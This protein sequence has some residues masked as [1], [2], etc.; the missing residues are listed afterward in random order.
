M[1][2]LTETQA[3]NRY[4]LVTS[5]PGSLQIC[6]AGRPL[7]WLTIGGIVLGSAILLFYLPVFRHPL[8]LVAA[9]LAVAGLGWLVPALAVIAGQLM[10]AAMLLVAVMLGVRAVLSRRPR[11]TVLGGMPSGSS[12]QSGNGRRSV[13]SKNGN[14][15]ANTGGETPSLRLP[16]TVTSGNAAGAGAQS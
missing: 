3:G 1:T 5:D 14:G 8:L 10:I 16:E 12:V 2:T 4:L 9:G 11:S 7:L 13:E 6:E 15:S